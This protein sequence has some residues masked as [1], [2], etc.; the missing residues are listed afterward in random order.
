[1]EGGQSMSRSMMRYSRAAAIGVLLGAV[2]VVA[3]D[4]DGMLATIVGVAVMG[5]VIWAA[6][7]LGT[8]RLSE[9]WLL[10]RRD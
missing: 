6:M 2:V 8:G 1:M 4:L 5:T 9:A 7:T 10:F 3:L